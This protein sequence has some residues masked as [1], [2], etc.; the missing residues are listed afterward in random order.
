M[1]DRVRVK[2]SVSE[3]HHEWGSVSHE[4]VGKVTGSFL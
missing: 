3:P 1:G 2:A 4:S